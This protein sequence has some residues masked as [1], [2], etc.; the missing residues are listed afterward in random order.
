M[1]II[2]DYRHIAM[3]HDLLTLRDGTAAGDNGYAPHILPAATATPMTRGVIIPA[4]GAH[5]DTL[6]G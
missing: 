6:I 2:A 1:Q 3:R 5:L 4:M